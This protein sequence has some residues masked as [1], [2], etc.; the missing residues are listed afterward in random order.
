MFKRF[1]KGTPP[2]KPEGYGE[3]KRLFDLGVAAAAQERFHDAFLHYSASV[4]ACPNPAPY[5]NRARILVKKIRHKEALDDL[6]QALRLDQ[7]QGQEML[8][9]IEAEIEEVSPYVENYRNGT[10]ENLVED[11]RS[12]SGSFSDLRYVA[13]RIWEVTFRS[14]GNESQPYRHPLS[15]YHF[16][17]ELDNVA[18]FEDPDVYPEAKE[19]H[20]LYPAAF[21][22]EQVNNPVDFAAYSRSEALLN[23]FLCSY[24]EPDMRKLRRLM[25]YDIHEYLLRRDYGDQL[26]SMTNPQPEVIQSAANFLSQRSSATNEPRP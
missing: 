26:W 9:E 14:A 17:N 6:W 25:L 7:E 8:S 11:F 4:K 5:L 24:D 10:R 1:S 22:A 15:E 20:A 18:R 23:S 16:F 2:Q 21:I 3:G 12:H 13:Q 19:F